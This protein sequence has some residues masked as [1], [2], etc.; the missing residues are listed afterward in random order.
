MLSSRVDAVSDKDRA[1]RDDLERLIHEKR[2]KVSEEN[3]R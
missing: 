3:D 1:L 2:R